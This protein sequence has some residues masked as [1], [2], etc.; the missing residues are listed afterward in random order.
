MD[1]ALTLY[2]YPMSRGRVA[3]S[4]LEEIGAPYTADVVAFGP[5]MTLAPRPE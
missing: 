3:R 2:T 4:M 5:E 1:N